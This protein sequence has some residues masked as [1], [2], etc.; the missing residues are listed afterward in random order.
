M[1]DWAGWLG[2]EAVGVSEGYVDFVR[3]NPAQ[4]NVYDKSLRPITHWKARKDTLIEVKA[5]TPVETVTLI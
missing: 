4:K 1:L 3:C 2:F 5:W